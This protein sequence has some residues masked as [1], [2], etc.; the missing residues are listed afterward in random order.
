MDSVERLLPSPVFA[1]LI[2]LIVVLCLV[3]TGLRE[4]WLGGAGT[5]DPALA[6]TRFRRSGR[7]RRTSLS[8]ARTLSAVLLALTTTVL[9][10]L[11]L[12]RIAVLPDGGPPS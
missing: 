5:V 4:A 11:T 12:V 10:V 6:G 9:V 1:V 7:F 2:G 8:G 3:V